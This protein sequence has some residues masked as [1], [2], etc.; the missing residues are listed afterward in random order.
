M[1]EDSKKRRSLGKESTTGSD[2]INEKKLEPKFGGG[3]VVL[4]N[5]ILKV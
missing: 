4:C 5:K 2:E 1:A 3:E